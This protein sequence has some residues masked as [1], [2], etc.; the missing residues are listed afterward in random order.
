MTPALGWLL[1]AWLCAAQSCS[2]LVI[3]DAHGDPWPTRTACGHQRSD[4]KASLRP[5][6]STRFLLCAQAFPDPSAPYYPGG[7][8]D[9]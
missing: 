6:Q 4:F 8:S 5:G 1:F 3:G 7:W 9:E 2:L